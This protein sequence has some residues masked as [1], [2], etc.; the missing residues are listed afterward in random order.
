MF[1]SENDVKLE[2]VQMK[3]RLASGDCV[4]VAPAKKTKS[5]VWKSSDHVHD[6][7]NEPVVI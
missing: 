5:E 6:E 4:L 1:P 2:A 3:R 7:N